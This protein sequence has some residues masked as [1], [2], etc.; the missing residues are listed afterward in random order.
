[1][2]YEDTLK[3]QGKGK[4]HMINDMPD[5]WQLCDKCGAAVLN[6]CLTEDDKVGTERIT[7][8]FEINGRSYT[9]N[10][11]PVCLG[12]VSRSVSAEVARSRYN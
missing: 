8:K 9:E 1:M 5:G 6:P 2:S 10:Y 12:R 3:R 11:P 4:T 7:V